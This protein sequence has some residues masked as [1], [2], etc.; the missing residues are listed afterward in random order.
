MKI[1]DRIEP[2][3]RSALDAAVKQ[4]EQR[5]DA[6]LAAF[7]DGTARLHGLELGVAI[8]GFIVIDA[9]DGKPSREE[10][11]LLAEK[12]ASL[13]AWAGVSA[14]DADRLLDTILSGKPLADSFDAESA[15]NLIFVVTACILAA[16]EKVGDGEWWFNYLDRVE[17]AIEATPTP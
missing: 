3:V 1:D 2:L 17:S 12:V 5:F 7:P 10:T 9:Y 14:A 8:C 11:R 4:D 16:S 15:I 13:S 6:A